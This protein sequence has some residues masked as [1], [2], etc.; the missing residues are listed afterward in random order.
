MRMRYPVLFIPFLLLLAACGFTPVYGTAGGVAGESA[1]AQI[2]VASIPDR[3]G[4]ALR[5]R[6]MDRFYRDGRPADPLWTLEV[7]PLRE[8]LSEIDVT[9]EA[10]ATRGQLRLETE[11]VLR[12]TS[13]GRELLR[14]KLRA[15]TGYNILAS[16]FATRVTEDAA[17]LGA[18]EDLARQIESRIALHVAD[19]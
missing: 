2:A 1:L 8:T 4:Q 19:R 9:R 12:E 13:G 11:F 14:Q 6:L 15:T 3:E 5:N 7:G 17:R 18:I 10:D 16:R